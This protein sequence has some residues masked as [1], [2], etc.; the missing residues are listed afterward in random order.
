MELVTTCANE[1]EQILLT[2]DERERNEHR[3]SSSTVPEG[4]NEDNEIE[5]EME[6]TS[7]PVPENADNLKNCHNTM[8]GV[9]PFQT[10][11]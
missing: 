3:N 7:V 6:S 2:E 5:R 4:Q 1:I 10:G 8:N 9:L 11:N